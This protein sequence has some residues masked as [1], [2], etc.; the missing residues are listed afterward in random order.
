MIHPPFHKDQGTGGAQKPKV[1]KTGE[2]SDT[3]PLLGDLSVS[4]QDRAPQRS[5]H[6]AA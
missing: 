3:A 6:S 1:E 2:A 4:H 5:T